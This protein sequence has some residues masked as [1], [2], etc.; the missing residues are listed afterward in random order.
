G[1]AVA[2]ASLLFL[3]RFGTGTDSTVYR[4]IDSFSCSPQI[5]AVRCSPKSEPYALQS[6][7]RRGAFLH[8][9][10]SMAHPH[11]IRFRRLVQ[12]DSR[13]F[14]L[15]DFCPS[16]NLHDAIQRRVFEGDNGKVK[17]AFAPLL[18]A[19]EECH[20]LGIYHQNIKLSNILCSED[21]SHLWLSGF[22]YATTD[23]T[24]PNYRYLS[25]PHVSPESLQR[26]PYSVARGFSTAKNDIWALGIILLG[27]LTGSYPWTLADCQV[28][29]FRKY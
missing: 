25:G 10:A 1:T 7:R 23:E 6:A 13:I 22:T 28:E 21:G 26:V 29:S 27:I 4:A 17:V 19:L 14:L 2:N 8:R 18:D 9:E 11:I 5:C 16:G 24:S 15:M 3:E 20:R 12:E